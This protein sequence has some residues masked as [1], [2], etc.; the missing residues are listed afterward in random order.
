MAGNS[1][2]AR[3]AQHSAHELAFEREESAR[4]RAQVADLQLNQEREHSKGRL[5]ELRF[6]R[7][8]KMVAGLTSEMNQAA[9]DAQS[10]LRPR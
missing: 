3:A 1:Q 4:L 9:D 2:A 8:V 6:A 7:A 10:V 5:L